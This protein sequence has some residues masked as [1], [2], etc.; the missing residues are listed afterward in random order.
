MRGQEEAVGWG[1]TAA[2]LDLSLLRPSR[3]DR[4]RPGNSRGAS[5]QSPSRYQCRHFTQHSP[6]PIN[7]TTAGAGL[8]APRTSPVTTSIRYCIC[9]CGAA[10]GSGGGIACCV[11]LLLLPRARAGTAAAALLRQLWSCHPGCSP[12]EVLG[13][14]SRRR[15]LAAGAVLLGSAPLLPLR[16]RRQVASALWRPTTRQAMPGGSVGA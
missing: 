16:E 8:P 6:V 7:L 13:A 9:R 14:L 4:S 11:R 3:A 2:I 12:Y 1:A 15:A 10:T 5:P